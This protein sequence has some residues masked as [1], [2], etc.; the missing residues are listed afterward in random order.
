MGTNVRGRLLW[1]WQGNPLR[2]RSDVVEAW[3]VLVTGLVMVVGG[4]TAGVMAGSAVDGAMRQERADRHRVPAV[5]M[6]NAPVPRPVA[7]GTDSQ[8]VRVAVRWTA[9]G[10]VVHTGTVQVQEGRRAGTATVVWTDDRGRRVA[11]PPSVEQGVTRAALAG[12]SSTA[13]VCVV[14]LAGRG[15]ARWRLDRSRTREWERAWA[16]VGP[17]WSRRHT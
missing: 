1:R 6:E 15:V 9:P 5:L 12:A 4:P 7:D 11:E 14:A 16:E 3:V 13:G 2:R 8:R 10:G 17:R